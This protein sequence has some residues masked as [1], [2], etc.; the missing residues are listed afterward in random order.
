M[1]PTRRQILD[2]I[3]REAHE[4][5]GGC[6][7][8]VKL[9]ILDALSDLEASGAAWVTAELDRYA[10]AGAARA[11]ADWRRRTQIR[12][13]TRKGTNVELPAFGAVTEATDDGT[14]TVQM[15]LEDLTIDQARERIAR[16][17][18]S[19]DTYSREITLLRDAVALM[20]AE[21]IDRVGDALAKL[22]AA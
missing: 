21:G 4:S 8:D 12:S 15:L 19:R 9:A 17:A 10:Q 5:H 20:E 16:L 14:R 3:I 2:D 1:E 6:S 22:A 18:K 11:Y 7:S 13:K